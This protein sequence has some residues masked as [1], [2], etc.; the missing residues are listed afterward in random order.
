MA[1]DPV[2]RKRFTDEIWRIVKKYRLSGVDND[3]EFPRTTDGTMESNLQLMKDLAELCRGGKKQ[4][5]LTM[6]VTSGMYPGARDAAITDE[7]FALVDWFNVMVYGN[8][9]ET[10]PG[11][12]HSTYRMLEMS[13]DYWV[14]K[15]GLDPRKYV[16]GLPL[17]GLAS[18]LPKK[19]SS[20]SFSKIMEQ[21]GAKALGTDSGVRD[22][23][24]TYHSIP[25]LLQRHTYH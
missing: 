22:Q 3:W 18:G 24:H 2:L 25:C 16:M 8:F 6:A 19:T 12:H 11:Q 14:K 7:V 9:S 21:N 4:Y 20:T 1:S 13:Y 23:Q 17:Y 10:K 5:Y 15:R